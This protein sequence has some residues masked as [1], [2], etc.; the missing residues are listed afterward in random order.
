MDIFILPMHISIIAFVAEM[1]EVMGLASSEVLERGI[2]R[3]G[4]SIP[5]NQSLQ[6]AFNHISGDVNCA[7][8]PVATHEALGIFEPFDGNATKV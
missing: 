1:I 4:R 7:C 3:R 2:F 8:R 5:E 6:G